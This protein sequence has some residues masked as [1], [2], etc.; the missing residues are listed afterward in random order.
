MGGAIGAGCFAGSSLHAQSPHAIAIATTRFLSFRTPSKVLA[1]AH[2]FS[3]SAGS[4]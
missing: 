4:S 1:N 2:Y 3:T